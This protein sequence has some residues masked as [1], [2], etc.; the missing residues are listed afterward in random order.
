MVGDPEAMER[1]PKEES[2]SILTLT[3]EGRGMI[4][5]G[6]GGETWRGPLVAPLGQIL[7]ISTIKIAPWLEIFK[8][9]LL[10]GEGTLFS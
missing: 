3:E 6:G 1:T 2:L 5:G 4:F 7:W 8:I 10:I 9:Y